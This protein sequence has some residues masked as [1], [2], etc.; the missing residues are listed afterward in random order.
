MK[1]YGY[2]MT[3]IGLIEIIAVA[4]QIIKVS[5]VSTRQFSED[6]NSIVIANCI[7]QLAMYFDEKLTEFNLPI[8][9]KGTPFQELV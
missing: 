1:K 2:L 7:Q 5:F 3:K 8:A 4:E 6:N 9:L